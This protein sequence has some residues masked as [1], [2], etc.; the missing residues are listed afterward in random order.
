MTSWTLHRSGSQS[1]RFP[2]RRAKGHTGNRGQA[3]PT[4]QYKRNILASPAPT[5]YKPLRGGNPWLPSRQ[6]SER[7]DPRPTSLRSVEPQ[8]L[9][10]DD[11]DGTARVRAAL[12][13]VQSKLHA[14]AGFDGILT[15]LHQAE[16]LVAAT[17]DNELERT[18][19]DIRELIEKL[20]TINAKVQTVV[21]LKRL[22]S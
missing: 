20:L 2:S 8:R 21:R 12:D 15:W 19:R 17:S 16:R 6:M 14:A 4:A 10:A 9:H 1:E 22:L 3:P 5:V 11:G 18:R 7:E 13:V